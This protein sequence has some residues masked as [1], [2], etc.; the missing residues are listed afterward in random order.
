[1]SAF[2][3]ILRSVVV[4]IVVGFACFVLI[5][6]LN[7]RW[8]L[9]IPN[10]GPVLWQMAGS[11]VGPYIDESPWQGDEFSSWIKP[12]DVVVSVQRKAGTNWMMHILH[13]MRTKGVDERSETS[14]AL[15]DTPWIELMHRPGQD[16]S[17]KKKLMH[18]G[19]FPAEGV[20]HQRENHANLDHDVDDESSDVRKLSSSGNSNTTTSGT[21]R[22]RMSSIHHLEPQKNTAAM[23]DPVSAVAGTS[24][25][26]WWDNE[27]FPFRVFKSHLLP[28]EG[29]EGTL[30]VRENRSVKFIAMVRNL[31]DSA[32]SL[33]TFFQEHS[34]EWRQLWGGYPPEYKTREETLEALLANPRSFMGYVRAWLRFREDPN[35]LLLHYADLKSGVSAAIQ[36]AAAA[37]AN[38]RRDS[39]AS[40][41]S[42]QEG[43]TPSK[44]STAFVPREDN[45]LRKIAKFVGEDA[46]IK[47]WTPI[48]TRIDFKWMKARPAKWC[49]RLW[50]NEVVVQETP[51]AA[52]ETGNGVGKSDLDE[53]G[54]RDANRDPITATKTLSESPGGIISTIR[55]VFNVV[56]R[57]LSVTGSALTR[58]LLGSS[59]HG[60]KC[61]FSEEKSVIV[62]KGGHGAG[63]TFF[64]KAM[65]EKF[66]KKLVEFFPDP[67]VRRWIMEGGELPP[68]NNSEGENVHKKSEL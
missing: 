1:M 52:D 2:R 64:S 39:A 38:S 66:E 57:Q 55:T 33:F 35:V 62:N 41:R 30:Q 68:L 28:L 45:V 56:S 32:A 31:R 51:L 50:G 20:A 58:R 5:M 36:D 59:Q 27:A 17:E 8:F 6:R 42:G 24:M 49:Y 67:A 11:R 22:T 43:S 61:V 46:K 63:E 29:S 18:D 3:F 34:N 44:T 25:R 19:W 12:N 14:D 9:K 4:V 10:V 13:Q 16:W 40:S 7:P 37:A 21:N 26:S 15:L 48:L 53:D 65:N 60:V 54:E 23:Q 47:D